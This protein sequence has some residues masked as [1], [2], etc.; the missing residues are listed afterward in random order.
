MHYAG[1]LGYRG[2]LLLDSAVVT[3]QCEATVVLSCSV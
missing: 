2:L 1:R 3:E